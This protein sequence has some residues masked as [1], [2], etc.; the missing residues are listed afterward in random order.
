MIFLDCAESADAVTNQHTDP[1]S[2]GFINLQPRLSH[3][4][5]RT[6]D[7]ILDEQIHF[8]DVFF[9]NEVERIKIADLAGNPGRIIA[10]FESCNHPDS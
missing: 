2:I 1:I 3:R 7:R 9:F 5:L 4:L 10:R 6:G 8:A